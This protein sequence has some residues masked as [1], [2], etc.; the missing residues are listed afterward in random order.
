MPVDSLGSSASTIPQTTPP[1]VSESSTAGRIQL[2]GDQI[3]Q[4][5]SLFGDNEISFIEG[6]P[7]S[8]EGGM[9]ILDAP[10]MSPDDALALLQSLNSKLSEESK[11]SAIEGVE[12]NAQ[13]QAAARKEQMEKLLQAA[14]EMKKAKESGL[15]GQIFGWIGAAIAIIAAV[16]ATIATF[17]AAAPASGL[18]IAGVIAAMTGAVLAAT[19]QVVSAIPGAMEGMGK[20]GS[21]AFMFTMMALQIA[22]AVVSLG[23]GA[24]S[25][26]GA[27]SSAAKSGADTAKMAAD[28]AEKAGKLQLTAEKVAKSAE[29]AVG[30]S[31]VGEGASDI[32]SAHHTATAE[33][34]RADVAELVKWLKALAAQDEQG[35]EFVRALQELQDKGWAVVVDVAK[36]SNEMQQSLVNN[37][38]GP[39]A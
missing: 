29:I 2:S 34:S 38:Q 3:R 35:I 37:L 23:A 15:I 28:I 7:N 12:A 14:E 33:Y 31:A 13:K 19:T 32:V 18:A 21:Q 10:I 30:L 25:M 27:T 39:S 17:G 26:A 8:A 20:D 16:A 1:G 6:D 36:E 24:A 5:Q 11:N 4:L 22:C 9:L